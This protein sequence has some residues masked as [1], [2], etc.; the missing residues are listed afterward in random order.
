MTERE[1]LLKFVKN[2]LKKNISDRKV[3]ICESFI[4]YSNFLH[5]TDAHKVI[6]NIND[7]RNDMDEWI[8]EFEFYKDTG[9]IVI[10]LELNDSIAIDSMKYLEMCDQYDDRR[11]IY[12]EIISSCNKENKDMF[13]LHDTN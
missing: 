8:A 12:S 3:I 6:T 5:W 10:F 13:I 9:K 2:E 7:S 4:E 1:I 11:T